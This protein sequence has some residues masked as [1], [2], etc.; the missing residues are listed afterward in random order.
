MI[1][2]IPYKIILASGSPRRRELLASLG[3]DFEVRVIEGIDESYPKKLPIEQVPL[4]LA[5]SKASAYTV[6]PDEV[7][8]T[9]DTVVVLDRLDL[10]SRVLGKP[11]DAAEAHRMLRALSGK[12]HRVITGVCLTTANNQRLITTTTEVTFRHLSNDEIDYY[13][14]HYKPFDKAGAYGIQEWI[15][16]IGVTGIRGSYFNVMG[17]PV[18]RIWDELQDMAKKEM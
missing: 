13:I 2:P 16:Y 3:L 6:G 4:Y 8:I 9:A 18:Q 10:G 1:R 17:L 11:Q 5:H 12:T 7:I 14:E 15:G